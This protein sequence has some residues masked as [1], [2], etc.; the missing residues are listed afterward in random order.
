MDMLGTGKVN[1][2]GVINGGRCYDLENFSRTRLSGEQ[3]SEST[4]VNT[5]SELVLLFYRPE[6]K[7]AEF[8]GL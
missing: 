5:R 3:L 6:G 8:F 4:P 7:V 1:L 2:G